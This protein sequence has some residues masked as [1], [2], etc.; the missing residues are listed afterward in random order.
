MPPTWKLGPSSTVATDYRQQAHFRTGLSSPQVLRWLAHDPIS[1][2]QIFII[3]CCSLL[4]PSFQL[5]DKINIPRSKS[6]SE[7]STKTHTDIKISNSLVSKRALGNFSH[8]RAQTLGH[9]MVNFL[10]SLAGHN[11]WPQVMWKVLFPFKLQ[12]ALRIGNH[13]VTNMLGYSSSIYGHPIWPPAF[14]APAVFT[15]RDHMF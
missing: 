9:E 11:Q 15:H 7:F 5:N 14:Q 3:S 6:C 8:Q 4:S 2:N 10:N 12:P 1:S 13:L